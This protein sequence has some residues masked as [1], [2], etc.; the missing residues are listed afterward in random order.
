MNI[1]TVQPSVIP[2]FDRMIEIEC[3]VLWSAAA[4]E[5]EMA[6]RMQE[7]RSAIYPVAWRDRIFYRWADAY[8]KRLHPDWKFE[9]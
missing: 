8:G 5:W 4:A 1:V 9:T 7:S 6:A 3:V 2:E